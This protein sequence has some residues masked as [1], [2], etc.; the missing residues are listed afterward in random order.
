MATATAWSCVK[1]LEG[2]IGTLPLRVYRRQADGSRIPAGPD[3]RL[4]Q[5]LARPWPGATSIDLSSQIVM[6]LS[7]YGEIAALE[8]QNPPRPYA[9]VGGSALIRDMRQV[10]YGTVTPYFEF[11]PTSAELPQ[12]WGADGYLANGLAGGTC[13]VYS[14]SSCYVVNRTSQFDVEV[15]RARLFDSDR[16]E[17]RLGARLDYLYPYPGAICRG[18][19]V[20]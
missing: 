11:P 7:L 5:L 9:Y 1:L 19:G 20:P 6:H 12:I 15:N 3:Q 14:P 8:A 13:H 4:A 18:T 2:S 10:T 16:S 17:I